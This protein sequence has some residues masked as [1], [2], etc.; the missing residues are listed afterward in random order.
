MEHT[1]PIQKGHDARLVVAIILV[2]MAMGMLDAISLLHLKMFAGYMTASIILIAVNIATSQAIVLSGLEAI[3][4]FYSGAVLGGRLVRRRRHQRLII[5]DMLL[6]VASLIALAAWIWS[7]APPGAPYI[8]LGLLAFAMGVQTSAT[9]HASLPDMTLPAATVVLHG[10]AHNSS[11]A[12][13]DNRGSWR[14]AA[15][16]GALFLGAVMGTLIS[17]HSVAQGIALTAFIIMMAGTVLL[18]GR[19]PLV[20]RLDR[21]S[22]P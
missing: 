9:R 8:T 19:L 11:V 18:V 5:G 2:T 17:A 4:C 21:I 3:A 13:G 12:G 22:I 14:R 20:V 6:G 15:A 7:A 16:I 10:L 1:P